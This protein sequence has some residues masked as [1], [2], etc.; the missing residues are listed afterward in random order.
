M[1]T[2]TTPKI[3]LIR[4]AEKPG[5]PPPPH[6]VDPD[7]EHDKESLIVQG[8]Q[9][10]GALAPFFAPAAGPLQSPLLATPAHLYASAPGDGSKSERPLQTITPLA[11]RL[12]VQVNLDFGKGDETALAAA[13]AGQGG[14]VLV[15]WQHE[16]IPAIANA[17]L[18]NDTT[19]PQKWPGSRFDV[20]WVFDLDASTGTYAFSQLPQQ[21]LAGDSD[22]VI[23]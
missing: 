15:A 2:P 14:V 16:A 22:S 18:G 5:D 20:V 6:G 13:I 19:V 21:L 11:Q 1:S 3:M 12:G 7:G 23:S 4:H 9:R 10:A 8:W 17:V